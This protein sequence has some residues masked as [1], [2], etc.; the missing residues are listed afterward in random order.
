M[1]A[2]LPEHSAGLRFHYSMQEKWHLFLKSKS[3]SEFRQIIFLNISS[4]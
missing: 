4:K 2:G 3:H 1:A